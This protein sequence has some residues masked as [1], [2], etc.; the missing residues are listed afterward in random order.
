MPAPPMQTPPAATSSREICP[1]RPPRETS[2]LLH[3]VLRFCF[4]HCAVPR[5][6]FSAKGLLHRDHFP[7][8]LPAV[9]R[10]PQPPDESLRRSP[11]KRFRG[12]RHFPPAV[13][14]AAP[15]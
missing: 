9:R 8:I 12:L 2:L 13:A 10:A 6:F 5:H 3:T 15:E 1:R 7:P 14:T 11:S 4:A